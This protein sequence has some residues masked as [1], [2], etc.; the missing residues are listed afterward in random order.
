M[1]RRGPVSKRRSMKPPPSLKA[2]PPPG[3]QDTLRPPNSQP[4]AHRSVETPPHTTSAS[5]N[6]GADWPAL[7]TELKQIRRSL[8]G[9]DAV[10]THE[11]A[12]HN[13]VDKLLES[14]WPA[15]S[16]GKRKPN[17]VDAGD[18]DKFQ[19]RVELISK[20]L[21]PWIELRSWFLERVELWQTWVDVPPKPYASGTWAA[22]IADA[23]R[24]T[25]ADP[26]NETDALEALIKIY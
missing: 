9:K 7:F 26:K 14:A 4:M 22:I 23:R 19:K 25:A 24:D 10:P 13:I 6:G 12:F 15:D 3:T 11:D 1:T 20:A 16:T 8:V 2:V 18:V 21:E 5:S 17:E